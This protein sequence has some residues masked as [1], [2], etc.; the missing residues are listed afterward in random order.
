LPA[1]SGDIHAVAVSRIVE[2]DAAEVLGDV[3]IVRISNCVDESRF[4]PGPGNPA[5][6]EQ[7]WPEP[8]L[9]VVRIGL[10]ASYARWKGHELF[11]EAAAKVRRVLGPSVRF[12]IVGGPIYQ[13]AGSQW[14]QQ[15][16]RDLAEFHKVPVN[17]VPFRQDIEE[18]YRALDVVV[19]CSTRPEP[20][21]LTIAEAMSCGRAVVASWD[22]GAVREVPPGSVATFPPGN[23]DA[24][25]GQ[26]LR[27]SQDSA[28]RKSLG[29]QAHQA[30]RIAFSSA[31]F[32]QKL[33]GLY[34]DLAASRAGVGD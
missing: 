23:A 27:I 21:G 34:R 16:L 28:I 22:A 17:F 18:V 1:L 30:A 19:H 8:E 25:A 5:A 20:F 10:V 12:Y 3:P 24:L 6:L 4:R 32:D 15:E 13:T 14:S 26:I 9:S 2:H 7:D 31:E 11:I 29:S 33:V